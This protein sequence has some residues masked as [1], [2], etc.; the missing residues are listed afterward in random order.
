MKI[1]YWITAG[2]WIVILVLP[3]TWAVQPR[4]QPAHAG[5]D[6]R[7]VAVAAPDAA[8][9]QAEA[10]LRSR[11]DGLKISRDTIL[12]TPKLVSATRGFLTGA[13]GKGKALSSSPSLVAGTIA[14]MKLADR[15]RELR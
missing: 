1:R 7:R 12:G 8:E 5:Y 10:A 6:K 2:L 14:T 11:V 9:L 15:F 4:P 13:E 3:K